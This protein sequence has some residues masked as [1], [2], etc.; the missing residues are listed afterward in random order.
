MLFLT[1]DEVSELTGRR[2]ARMQ[3]E[4]LRRMGIRHVVNAA[5]HVIVL[6]AHVERRLDSVATSPE[7]ARPNFSAI[8]KVA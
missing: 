8:Q 4:A 1:A 2:R 3:T 7:P 6:R 5:G